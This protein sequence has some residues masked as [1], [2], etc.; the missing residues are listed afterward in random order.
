MSR[1]H[2]YLVKFN[3]GSQQT[4]YARSLEH[5]ISLVANQDLIMTFEELDRDGNVKVGG[6]Y[7]GF[8]RN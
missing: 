2:T 4:V 7:V 3:D 1:N 5:A 8:S 6:I